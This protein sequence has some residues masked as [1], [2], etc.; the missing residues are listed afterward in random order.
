MACLNPIEHYNL[1]VGSLKV[2][3][4]ADFIEVED[5]EQFKVLQTVI[6][7]EIVAKK[8]QDKFKLFRSRTYQ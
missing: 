3:D 4:S 8:W 1:E 7:G 2:G 6:N 5:L